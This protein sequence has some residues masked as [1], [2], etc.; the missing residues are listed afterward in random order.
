MG[1]HGSYHFSCPCLGLFLYW[2]FFFFIVLFPQHFVHHFLCE[3]M[4]NDAYEDW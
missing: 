1:P 4:N 2:L 3:M